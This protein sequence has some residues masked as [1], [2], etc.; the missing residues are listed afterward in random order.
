MSTLM[1]GKGKDPRSHGG[2]L[3]RKKEHSGA[4]ATQEKKGKGTFTQGG[5]ATI[6]QR[7]PKYQFR[8]ESSQVRQPS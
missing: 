3:T 6:P 8:E 5:P 7:P 4:L 2:L 1:S